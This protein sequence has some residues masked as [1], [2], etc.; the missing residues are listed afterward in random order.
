MNPKR[1]KQ[2]AQQSI[3]C[4]LLRARCTMLLFGVC[5]AALF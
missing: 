4:R 2:S 1:A 5:S 3:A